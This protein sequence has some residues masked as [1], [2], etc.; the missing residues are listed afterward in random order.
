SR[1]TA[2]R[3]AGGRR[4]A[5]LTFTEHRLSWG[6]FAGTKGVST[7]GSQYQEIMRSAQSR[8]VA[9]EALRTKIVEAARDI[10]SEEGL[11]ALSMRALAERIE[12][13]PATIYLHF[14]IGRASCRERA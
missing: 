7:P 9:K 8:E 14:Q 12:Y 5:A 4:T 6:T 1:T 13:S 11:D 10:V 2:F 3:V